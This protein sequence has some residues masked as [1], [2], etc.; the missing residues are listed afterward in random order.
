MVVEG[1]AEAVEEAAVA[2]VVVAVEV[3]V[4]VEEEVVAAEQLL[5]A[6]EPTQMRSCWEEN[7]NTSKETDETLINSSRT[8]SPI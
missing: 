5:Q 1:E 4:V 3:E 2:E 7:P 8:S 6:E